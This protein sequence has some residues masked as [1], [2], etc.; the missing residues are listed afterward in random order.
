M[1]KKQKEIIAI[2]AV[3]AVG[4]ICLGVAIPLTVCIISQCYITT[5]EGTVSLSQTKQLCKVSFPTL[6]ED[7]CIGLLNKLIK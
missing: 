5:S 6:P 4:A 2:V 3:I 1:N 7:A